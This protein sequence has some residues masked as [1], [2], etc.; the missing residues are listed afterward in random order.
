LAKVNLK[1]EAVDIE[2]EIDAIQL[3]PGNHYV[4]RATWTFIP[5]SFYATLPCSLDFVYDIS[6]WCV[7]SP[8]VFFF[9]LMFWKRFIC[10]TKTYCF[11]KNSSG[12]FRPQSHSVSE[13]ILL[14]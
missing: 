12:I 3:L 13:I 8:G 11:G 10:T 1:N 4:W 9:T 2:E 14:H 6:F 5:F 7:A